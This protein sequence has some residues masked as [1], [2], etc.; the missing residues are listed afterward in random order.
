VTPPLW[1]EGKWLVVA[2]AGDAEDGY[3]LLS[4]FRHSSEQLAVMNE[5]SECP[6]SAGFLPKVLA[7]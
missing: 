5:G 6:E 2:G 1:R 7:G 3:D 4:E